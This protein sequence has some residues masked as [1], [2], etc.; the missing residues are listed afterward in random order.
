MLR[1][2]IIEVPPDLDPTRVDH[3][4]TNRYPDRSRTHIQGLIADGKVLLNGGAVKK[5]T[6]IHPGDRFT[7]LWP[8]DLPEV[9]PD[10]TIGLSILF[11]DADLLV[12]DKPANLTVHPGAGNRDGTLISALLHYDYQR[13]HGMLDADRRP[14]IVHRLDKDTTGV[15]VIGKNAATVTALKA[16]F[17]ARKVV[18]TY[19]GLVAG[20]PAKPAADIIAP[21]GRNPRNRKRMAVVDERG[22][23]AH[24]RYELIAGGDNCSLLRLIAVTGRTHQLRVHAQY[25]GHPILGDRLY[26]GSSHSYVQAPRQMLHAWQLRLPHPQSGA[27]LFFTATIPADFMAV[28]L[29]GGIDVRKAI[30]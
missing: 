6:L 16:A 20:I 8:E 18:K 10:A 2:E 17:C 21:I 22:K 9:Q 7:I 14:G 15:L 11:E 26:G 24:T 23:V 19:L 4:I 1:R 3:F 29:A 12:I 30:P 5:S 25:M 27:E 28:A 13:F